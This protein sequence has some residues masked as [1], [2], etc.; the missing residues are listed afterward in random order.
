MLPCLHSFYLLSNPIKLQNQL[1]QLVFKINRNMTKCPRESAALSTLASRGAERVHL[2][3]SK[4]MG[5]ADSWA[6]F[7]STC[8]MLPMTSSLRC[9]HHI[10]TNPH[11]FR[12]DLDS[13]DWSHICRFLLGCQSDFDIICISDLY[14]S[15][16]SY[17]H[18]LPFWCE[19]LIESGPGWQRYP[20][21]WDIL[22]FEK[23]L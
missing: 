5:L 21:S 12:K 10:W 8:T 22:E 9:P 17:F 23:V 14:L 11:I 6:C 20:Y 2:V 19:T 18:T 4:N 7:L 16:C 1:S 3:V 13:V 15:P